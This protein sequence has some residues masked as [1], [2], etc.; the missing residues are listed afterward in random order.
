MNVGLKSQ[1]R[2]KQTVENKRNKS[3]QVLVR[4][5]HCSLEDQ[6]KATGTIV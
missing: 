3:L 6:L 1:A 4:R 2:P 5:G